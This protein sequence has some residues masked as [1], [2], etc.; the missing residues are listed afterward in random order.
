MGKS[1]PKILRD[2]IHNLITFHDNEWDRLLLKL[3]GCKEVQRL[4]RIKQLGFSELVFPGAN[5]NRFA[6]SLGVV[7]IAKKFLDQFDRV[8]GMPLTAA[9][10]TFVLTA[11]LLHDVGH[12]PF[13]HAFEKVT[14]RDH[15][16]YTSD[17]IRDPSTE[18]SQALSGYDADM[19]KRLADFFHTENEGDA[20]PLGIPAYL[21]QVISSQLDA[22]RSD[23][24]LRDSYSTGTDYGRYDLDWLVAHLTPQADGRRFVLSRKALNATEAYVFARFHMYRT[25]YYHKTTRAAEVMLRLI[26]R[27][28]NELLGGE[29]TVEAG[30][31]IAPDAPRNFLTAFAGQMSLSDYLG[32]DDHPVT[33]FLKACAASSDVVLAGLCS[34]LLNR[35]LYKAV[36][37]SGV[38][39]AAVGAFTAAVQPVLPPEVPTD[40]SFVV[41][42]PADTPYKPYEED[43]EKPA[44]QI[45]IEDAYGKPR[46]LAS[47]SQPVSQLQTRYELARYYFPEA[48]RDVIDP[49]A[50]SKLKKG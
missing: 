16:A 1:W 13:S 4:R 7:H 17:I 48:L 31:K 22:D 40:Y 20:L 25:V 39:I 24:L 12:G 43:A 8:T 32:L 36:D 14:G 11:A 29:K 44:T 23:Y 19:P 15:E 21:T 34:G 37:V 10:R 49:I 5:H 27:R 6:H 46:N 28:F 2:P 26:F 50:A 9:Q 30:R 47:L 35:R 33:E 42:T 18:V 38:S 3:L 41:D 45:Y